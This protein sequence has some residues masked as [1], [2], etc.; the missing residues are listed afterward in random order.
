MSDHMELGESNIVPLEGGWFLNKLTGEKRD[1][2]GRVFDK[3]GE[4]VHDPGVNAD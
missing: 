3:F 4:L 2:E 1:P